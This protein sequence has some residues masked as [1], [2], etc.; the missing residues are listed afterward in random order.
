M[1]SLG[2]RLDSDAQFDLDVSAE[3]PDVTN[4]YAHPSLPFP[5][6]A[7]NILKFIPGPQLDY[8]SSVVTHTWRVDSIARSGI[9]LASDMESMATHTHSIPSL[10]VYPGVIQLP[11]DGHP[12]LLGPDCGV[13]G[14]YPI[15]G[16]IPDFELRK[17]AWLRTGDSISL[18]PISITQSLSERER[19][20]KSQSTLVV[21]LGS[22]V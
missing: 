9:R 21:D 5:P 6:A 3:A 17:L 19:V 15:V 8:F 1:N 22:R 12:I 10:P 4:R 16:V 14:G 18:T 2:Y 11:P 20:R 7:R 13:T